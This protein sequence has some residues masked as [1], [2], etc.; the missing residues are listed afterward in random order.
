MHTKGWAE[1]GSR[2]RGTKIKISNTHDFIQDLSCRDFV[3]TVL[4]ATQVKLFNGPNIFRRHCWSNNG[5]RAMRIEPNKLI[6]VQLTTPRGIVICR[7][8]CMLG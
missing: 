3:T 1:V 6:T 4:V 8:T 5:T 2:K 7:T